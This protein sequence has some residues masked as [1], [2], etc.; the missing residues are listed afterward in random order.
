M[1]NVSIAPVFMKWYNIICL[2]ENGIP[3]HGTEDFHSKEENPTN[4]AFLCLLSSVS[5][6]D[7]CNF[8]K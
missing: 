5:L 3:D 7:G 2:K 8:I 4:I 1:N 6:I